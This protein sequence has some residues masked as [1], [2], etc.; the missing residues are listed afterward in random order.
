V[1]G[2]ETQV[3]DFPKRCLPSQTA[4]ANVIVATVV[5]LAKIAQRLKSVSFA[6]A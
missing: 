6:A 5:C 3:E 4:T 2:K 1:A